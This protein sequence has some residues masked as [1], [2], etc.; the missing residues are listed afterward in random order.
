VRERGAADQL[1]ATV[2]RGPTISLYLIAAALYL[3][4]S[5]VS[6]ALL[7]A[8]SDD[9]SFWAAVAPRVA[10]LLVASIALGW[11]TRTW[12]SVTLAVTPTGIAALFGYADSLGED[13]LLWVLE[14]LYAPLYAL[15]IAGGVLIG[16]AFERRSP[17]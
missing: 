17:S 2:R 1:E 4:V 5:L 7:D 10:P 15:L 9:P 11:I 3:A 14:L 16:R 8:A 12:A 13:V 6:V